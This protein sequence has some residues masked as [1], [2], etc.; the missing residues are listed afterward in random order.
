MTRRKGPGT[1]WPPEAR[2]TPPHDPV[3]GIAVCT[4]CSIWRVA[5]RIGLTWD[6]LMARTSPEFRRPRPPEV[7]DL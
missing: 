2:E 5:A 1:D 4:L 7:R 3:H 6:E